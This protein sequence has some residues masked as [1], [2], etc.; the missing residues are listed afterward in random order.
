M[1][2]QRERLV[3]GTTEHEAALDGD[4]RTLD[5]LREQVRVADD[6]ATE[7][8]AGVDAQDGVIRDARRALDAIRALAAELDVARATAESDLAHLAQ[9]ALDA[10]GISLDEVRE[11]VSRMEAEGIVEPDAR[12]IRAA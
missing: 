1:T 5:E 4:F 6:R 8:R 12:A 7:L 11:D 3:A 2:E 9:Q 10:V